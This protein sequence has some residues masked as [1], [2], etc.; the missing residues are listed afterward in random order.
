MMK[1]LYIEE[2]KM[3][4]M[5]H[6]RLAVLVLASICLPF[7]TYADTASA[8]GYTW[9]YLIKGNVAVLTC[10]P[11]STITLS[12]DPGISPKPNGAVTIPSKLGGKPVTVIGEDVFKNCT[13]LT[14]VTM[15][16]SIT[17]IQRY[18]FQ[19]CSGLTSVPL[20]DGIKFVS[21]DAFPGCNILKAKWY[22][23]LANSS[24][25]GVGM[26][27]VKAVLTVTNVVVHHVTT[28]V[29][30]SAVTPPVTTGI[31]N[32]IAEVGA[33][34]AIAVP[35]EWANQYSGFAAKFGND[36]TAAVTKPTGKY[37]GAGNAMYVWQDYVAGTDP[38]DLND[39][40]RASITFDGEGKP[41]ISHSPELTPTEAAKRI[42]RTF[43]KV[44]LND[45]DWTLV[46]GNEED[47]NF[48]K[49]TVEMK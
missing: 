8:N 31:V 24:A 19:G 23:T 9:T 10:G 3:T 46:N 40:F 37:D 49:V 22:V 7:L 44:R 28:S 35:S 27:G 20:P 18:A 43:G 38:T 21:E 47:Y 30:S 29:Q 12:Y 42:Y 48:F 41:V 26:D 45:S 39:V 33:S 25:A 15:P 16:N 36:F 17:N 32:V 34:G 14:S 6:C 1:A 2:I 4:A 13:G 11:Y 5:R